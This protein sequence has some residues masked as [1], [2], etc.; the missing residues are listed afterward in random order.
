M[1][2]DELLL[3]GVFRQ[4]LQRRVPLGLQD[5]LDGIEALRL[6]FGPPGTGEDGRSELQA[7]CRRLWARNPDEVRLIARI[8]DHLPRAAPLEEQ[9]LDGIVQPGPIVPER[10]LSLPDPDAQQPS[11]GQ[12]L[13]NSNLGSNT[14]QTTVDFQPATET[15]G[16]PIPPAPAPSSAAAENFVLQVQRVI[17][18]RTLATLWRRFRS[19]TR[20]GARTELDIEKTIAER[21]RHG[22]LVSAVLRPPRVNSARLVIFADASPSMA[23]WRPFLETVAGSLALSHLKMA[24]I[25]YFSNVPARS[26]FRNPT[27]TGRRSTEEVLAGAAGAGLLIISDA[28]AARRRFSRQRSRATMAF[29]TNA[30]HSFRSIVWVNPL[31][32]SRWSGTTAATLASQGPAAFLPL[33]VP[34]LIRAVDILRG[35]RTS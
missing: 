31:P 30:S 3:H 12:Q 9:E 6:G 2:I 35:A 14:P 19:L 24:E 32:R 21:C 29:L 17:S 5:Y 15:G 22:L 34:S 8:F 20:T 33:E 28:G 11:A 27:L 18:E 26:V 13:K 16:I 23:P 1:S 7:L 4:L 10:F 25:Y